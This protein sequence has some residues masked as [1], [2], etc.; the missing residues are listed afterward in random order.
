[1]QRF[2]A[3]GVR[4][5]ALL[6]AGLIYTGS[7][8]ADKPPRGGEGKHG[9]E[10]KHGQQ[11]RDES[12]DRDDH[13]RSDEG[14]SGK[15]KDKDKAHFDE[16]SRV[17]VHDYYAKSFHEGR[18]PPGLAKKHDGCMPPGQAKAWNI[19]RPL[20]REVVYYPVPPALV[21]QLGQPPSGHRYVRVAGDILLL[22]V[23]T[24]MV[25]DAL[26]NLGSL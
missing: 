16:H 20:P 6:A 7:A 1:M 25:V 10:G 8:L 17:V 3:H 5:L 24:G 2:K 14:G 4:T 11:D 9:K 19:G 22:A 15:H 12:R 18:C 13:G 21:T 23:G 26:Q